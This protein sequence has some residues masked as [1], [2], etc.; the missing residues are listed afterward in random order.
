MNLYKEKLIGALIGIARA[1]D[2]NE[3]LI[4]RKS[5]A[6]IRECLPLE[7]SNKE[8]LTEY[9][10]RVEAVKRKMVPD[11]FHCA[12]PCGRTAA[13]DLGDLDN[14]EAGIR[15]QKI[16]LLQALIRTA[17]SGTGED[18]L[19]YRG[20]I[21]LGMDDYPEKDLLRILQEAE[22]EQ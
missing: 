17:E 1:T 18:S 3:H 22:N 20:L 19:L 2:G 10:D 13:Y 15:H 5:T 4:S 6:L 11:C 8:D 7:P 21:V 9:L 12:D 14:L 16:R